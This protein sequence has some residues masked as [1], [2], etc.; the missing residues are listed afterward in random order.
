MPKVLGLSFTPRI[1]ERGQEYFEKGKVGPIEWDEQIFS[2]TV[3]GSSDHEY[4][5]RG[6]L[7]EQQIK[8][9]TC[10]CPYAEDHELCKHMAFRPS[11]T[12]RP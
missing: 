12:G 6:I 5:V 9:I 4:R 11:R 7:D 1:F 3:Q 2:A 10:N 8:W